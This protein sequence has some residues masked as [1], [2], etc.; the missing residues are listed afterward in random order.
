MIQFFSE[1]NPYLHKVFSEQLINCRGEN[2]I[3]SKGLKSKR[4]SGIL[5]KTDMAGIRH[6][7]NHFSGIISKDLDNILVFR[8]LF[9]T[10]IS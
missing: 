2:A 6:G 1:S 5:C 9:L 10:M 3:A 8:C 7:W 4:N